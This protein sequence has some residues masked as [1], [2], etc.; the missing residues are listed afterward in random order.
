M[1][2]SIRINIQ[3]SVFSTNTRSE[4][5]ASHAPWTLRGCR[6]QG[7]RLLSRSADF[8]VR[9]NVRPAPGFA[10]TKTNWKVRAPAQNK[11]PGLLGQPGSPSSRQ[12]SRPQVLEVCEQQTTSGQHVRA[13][14]LADPT[15]RNSGPEY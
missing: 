10:M 15:D 13:T 3:G 7:I 8:P 4:R 6:S 12:H 14:F 1:K 11:Q 9:S 2:R 5:R